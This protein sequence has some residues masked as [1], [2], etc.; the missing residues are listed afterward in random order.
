M[1]AAHILF[2]SI[3]FLFSCFPVCAENDPNECDCVSRKEYNA[4]KKE[5]D[6]LK[7]EFQSLKQSSES[8]T[9]VRQHVEQLDRKISKV[10]SI[11]QKTQ[12]GD[13]KMLIVGDAEIGFTNQKKSN[14][15]FSA[16]FNPML[17][18]Q[19]N[20]RL[21]FEGAL[22]LSLSGP[23][24]NGDNSDS[25]AELDSAYLV[26]TLNESA[27]VGAGL[28]PV[29]FTSYHNHFDPGWINKLPTDPLVY[30]DNGIA[31]DSS[32]GVFV[33]GAFPRRKNIIN[34]A[35]WVTNG[36]ALI[37]DD[38]DAAGSLNFDNHTDQNNNKAL[39]GR[40]GI[41]PSPFLELGYSIQYAK[42]S[43]DSF[44]S[45]YSTI[46]GVDL[47]YVRTLEC[48]KGR[49]T[50]RG[51]WVWS[52]LGEA[53]YDPM[54]T[55][56]FGP[57]RFNNNRNGGYFE[58]AYRPTEIKD[59]ILKN[60]EY[61]IRYDRLDVSD[62]APG[63]GIHEQWTPG[64]DYWLTPRTVLKTAYIFDNQENAEDQDGVVFQFATGF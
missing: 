56:G 32:L 63:G 6:D 57:L 50:T 46:Q 33:T 16:Q 2:G 42:V 44:E 14:S 18:W 27:V 62:S 52:R 45:L 20:E 61:V 22:E 4:L 8:Q 37:T 28:F 7:A 12:L 29:P 13:T 38:P 11:A 36:P 17:L 9:Q 26:Y 19:L 3:F 21:F 51:A 40:I 5:F 58:I 49:I 48:I 30:G 23:D 35:A 31:P 41:L 54:G 34:Y 55:L 10:E 60:F 39:G 59:E 53:T 1:K 25:S 43:P 64:I 15:T 24:D 47:N